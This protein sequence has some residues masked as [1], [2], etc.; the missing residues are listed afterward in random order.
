M[1][2]DAASALRYSELRFLDTL[3]RYRDF[4]DIGTLGSFNVGRLIY[5][6]S[7]LKSLF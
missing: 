6:S 4:E 2:L 5:F 3:F 1:K 7:C